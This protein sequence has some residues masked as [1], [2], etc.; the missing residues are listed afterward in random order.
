MSNE[1][2]GLTKGQSSPTRSAEPGRTD[3]RLDAVL[4]GLSIA[5]TTFL[6][7]GYSGR[8]EQLVRLTRQALEHV[9]TR[10]GFAFLEVISPCVTYWD[11]YP[12]WEQVLVDVDA[13]PGYDPSDRVAAFAMTS[14]LAAEGRLP[15]GLIY[16][17][18][19]ASPAPLP[20]PAQAAIDPAQ[21]ASRYSA[22]LEQYAL[23]A[24][25]PSVSQ[26]PSS[27]FTG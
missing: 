15:A 25:D 9:R 24:V 12:I 27:V 19:E 22:I 5:A 1:T 18:P 16:H 4:M 20:A 14:R 8:S 23:P 2:Y 21:L 10:Q 6:A 13:E 17:A 3:G 7:R 26:A 11:T